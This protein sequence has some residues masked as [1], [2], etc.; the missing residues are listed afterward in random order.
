MKDLMKYVSEVCR[1][2]DSIGIPYRCVQRWSVNTRAK[3]RWGDC[4]AL[5]GGKFEISISAR[6]LADE[7]GDQALRDTIAHELLHTADGCFGHRGL[8]KA[9][10]AEV[11]RRLPG[12][13]VSRVTSAKDK[14]FEAKEESPKS[15]VNYRYA[16]ECV[17]CGEVIRRQ[18]ASKAIKHPER[19]RCAKCGGK[20][21]RTS[22]DL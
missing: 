7:A 17:K 21:R 15:P 3:K 1:D 20:L 10:A 16:L 6:L 14:G 18:K 13:S 4:R 22:P 5:G 12:Y 2:L 9:L 19:Y 11:N 8:W